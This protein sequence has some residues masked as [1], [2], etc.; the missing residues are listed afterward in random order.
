MAQR[1]KAME[2]PKMREQMLRPLAGRPGGFPGQAMPPIDVAKLV[3]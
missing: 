3:A 2:D 1:M